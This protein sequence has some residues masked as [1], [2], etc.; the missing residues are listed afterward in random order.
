MHNTDPS[1]FRIGGKLPARLD[2]RTLQLANFLLPVALPAPPP[3]LDYCSKVSPW[4]MYANDKL[5]DCTIAGAAHHIELWGALAGKPARPAQRTITSVYHK[6]S[7]KDEGC[8]LLDV[9][10]Y[11]RHTGIAGH[12]LWGY[13]AVDRK[14]HDH[15]KLSLELF[16]GVYVGVMLPLSAQNQVG[17]VWD[18]PAGGL[19]GSGAPNS[20]GG[21]C[22]VKAGYNKIGPKVLTWGAVQQM[23]WAF[24]DAYVDESYAPLTLDWAAAPKWSGI[25]F[26]ALQRELSAIGKATA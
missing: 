9:L 6:L 13:A 21:H 20:W 3:E 14:N 5:G 17:K 26:E 22:V 2:P 1:R 25:D 11:W 15:V 12:K 16:G 10:S 8:V 7:P 4:G 18:V 23:T 19:H 24:W